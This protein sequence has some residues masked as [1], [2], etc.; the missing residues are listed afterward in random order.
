MYAYST[1]SMHAAICMAWTGDMHTCTDERNR[2]A[3]DHQWLSLL[4]KR[5]N[6]NFFGKMWYVTICNV[7]HMQQ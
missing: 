6:D 7:S 5:A 2:V 3:H 4:H 1:A